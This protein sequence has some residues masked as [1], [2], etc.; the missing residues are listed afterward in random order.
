M[1]KEEQDTKMEPEDKLL[2]SLYWA[3]NVLKRYFDG[4]LTKDEE[5]SVEKQL[6]SI[7]DRLDSVDIR[8][9]KRQLRKSDVTIR[10]Q[11]FSKLHSR[12]LKRKVPFTVTFRKY[13]AVAAVVAFVFGFSYFML[14]NE[15]SFLKNNFAQS[16]QDK[17][18][19]LQTAASEVKELVLPDGTIVYANADTRIEYDNSQFNKEQREIWLEGEA[20]FE[21][22]KNP[23]K[24]F[25]IHSGF[26]QTIVRG[27]SFNVKAYKEIGE[28]SVSV[29][30]GK[31]EVGKD[32]KTF[33]ILTP[34]KQLIYNEKTEKH[35]V[36][37]SNWEDAV[38]WKDLRLVLKN[39]NIAEFKLRIKQLYN[40]DITVEGNILDNERFGLSF[41]KNTDLVDVMTVV[42]Q[43]YDVKIEETKSGNIRIYRN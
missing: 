40:V 41:Q 14:F 10:K 20:F 33:A 1:K 25:I 39:A 30:T 18:I 27:T 11:V 36:S 9:S 29:R 24:P 22:A 34:N 6:Q 26:L 35:T 31:V 17:T 38:A 28:V 15:H 43:L 32:D 12:P 13:A 5:H 4:R 2:R 42:E 16:V 7:D 8:L 3:T 19:L 37:E 23:E 21:V